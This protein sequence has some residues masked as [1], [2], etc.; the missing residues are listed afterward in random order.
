[1][2]TQQ[3]KILCCG[4]VNGNFV[5][6]IKKISTTE[7]KACFIDFWDSFNYFFFFRM[8][9]SIHYFVLASFSATMTIQ[10]R[11]L[12]MEISNFQFQP[13]FWVCLNTM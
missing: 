3:A 7:K 11:K 6:L 9:H 2:A 4:D 5:E 8:A 13:T 12:S 10:M 1:M